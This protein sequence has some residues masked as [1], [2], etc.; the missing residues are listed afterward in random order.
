VLEQN[1]E[2]A[3]SSIYVL[4]IYLVLGFCGK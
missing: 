2:I 3:A 4:L 1:N